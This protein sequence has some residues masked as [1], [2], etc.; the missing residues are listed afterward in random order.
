MKSLTE[1]PQEHHWV[2][3]EDAL[4]PVEERRRLRGK[5]MIH[6]CHLSEETSKDEEDEVRSDEEGEEV[7]EKGWRKQENG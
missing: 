5:V 4:N 6:S 1:P 2:G 7:E 3:I